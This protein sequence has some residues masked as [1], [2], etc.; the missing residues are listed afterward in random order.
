MIVKINLQNTT[1]VPTTEGITGK[2]KNITIYHKPRIS[3]P[4]FSYDD[5][6]DSKITYLK[7]SRIITFR[8]N[9]KNNIAPNITNGKKRSQ[10][11]LNDI[12]NKSDQNQL[13]DN[14]TA[15]LNDNT[16]ATNN[17]HKVVIN[18]R[19]IND[20]QAAKEYN[21]NNN[22][23]GTNTMKNQ[24]GVTG[25]NLILHAIDD[26]N[27]T[28]SPAIKYLPISE[29]NSVHN[30]DSS[31]SKLFNEPRRENQTD[32]L[33]SNVELENNP[34][35][36]FK[37]IYPRRI[38]TEIPKQV[39][40]KEDE[41]HSKINVTHSN[42]N[43]TETNNAINDQY[44]IAEIIN[45]LKDSSK[46][47]TLQNGD[48][49]MT[50]KHDSTIK[51]NS[52][53]KATNTTN[54]AVK[55]QET[56]ESSTN[57]NP[58][59]LPDIWA[60]ALLGDE[61]LD[62]VPN[63]NNYEKEDGNSNLMLNRNTNDEL[64][65]ENYMIQNTDK[66]SQKYQNTK[67]NLENFSID[68]KDKE[69]P[70]DLIS[71]ICTTSKDNLLDYLRI[72]MKLLK[73]QTNNTKS[74]E[75]KLYITF[76]IITKLDEA[77]SLGLPTEF[78]VDE[79]AHKVQS[80]GK[81]TDSNSANK[82]PLDLHISDENYNEGSIKSEHIKKP[83][84]AHIGDPKNLT[85]SKSLMHVGFITTESNMYS[86]FADLVDNIEKTYIDI[87]D[88][89]IKLN[90]E[91]ERK[92]MV[93]NNEYMLVS[94]DFT[95]SGLPVTGNN[96]GYDIKSV[97][98]PST[99]AVKKQNQYNLNEADDQYLELTEKPLN[100]V[101]T[102]DNRSLKNLDLDTEISDYL[103]FDAD[104]DKNSNNDLPK[105]M[106]TYTNL[107]SGPKRNRIINNNEHFSAFDKH[108]NLDT[109]QMNVY[110]TKSSVEPQS[111]SDDK[112]LITDTYNVPY[113]KSLPHDIFLDEPRLLINS[114]KYN[115]I[116][117]TVDLENPSYSLY[118]TPSPQYYKYDNQMYYKSP[119]FD[120]K[121]L[122]KDNVADN[123]NKISLFYNQLLKPEVKD[124]K[125]T[126]TYEAQAGYD[127]KLNKYYFNAGD[128][129]NFEKIGE[130]YQNLS[131]EENPGIAQNTLPQPEQDKH[132]T[133][134]IDM[135]TDKYDKYVTDQQF[136]NYADMKID[137][138]P[139]DEASSMTST[140]SPVINRPSFYKPTISNFNLED[141]IIK[142]MDTILRNTIIYFRELGVSE[143]LIYKFF[144]VLYNY[145]LPEIIEKSL[146]ECQENTYMNIKSSLKPIIASLLNGYYLDKYQRFQELRPS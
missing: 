93:P 132:F 126:D 50:A 8:D 121:Y 7:D 44:S 4:K 42:V 15:I 65:I 96:D 99:S 105:N 6:G 83:T 118:M 70:Y 60:E 123:K 47:V 100:Y 77:K 37:K 55:S 46:P 143:E 84:Q 127:P 82:Q 146:R 12:Y 88:S 68:Y 124:L 109:A 98:K 117:P 57:I 21:L 122:L 20:T 13:I 59:I 48:K 140:N 43:D 31:I 38:S 27:E 2:V 66:Y 139:L 128:Q 35:N 25:D 90:P 91:S 11:I 22:Y 28:K 32:N 52:T 131:F 115:L 95:T 53:N 141:N 94:N 134:P 112:V 135:T 113:R 40:K 19:D 81:V 108:R 129:N 62:T 23:N 18:H 111:N 24:T 125:Y 73:L 79:I 92:S 138:L 85:S 3:K 144:T 106:K 74:D 97:I 33:I 63:V 45:E 137:H 54:I 110:D 102:N 120:N 80:F 30:N 41:L 104:K 130:N 16:S 17:L 1:A 71:N 101:L 64:K 58:N 75:E 87:E 61:T 49:N 78:I 76:G 26:K 9:N 14:A 10:V 136:P 56:T 69:I 51:R 36:D 119:N 133:E 86:T 142:D 114:N 67:S 89:E 145:V 103:S 116:E 107:P 29:F 39:K 5:D 34:L 72:L